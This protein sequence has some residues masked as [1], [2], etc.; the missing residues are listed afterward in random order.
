V[1]TQIKE[2]SVDFGVIYCTAAYSA[3]LDI[4]DYATAEMCGQ[5]VYPAAVLKTAANPEAAAA[6]LDFLTTG[7]AMAVFEAAGFSKP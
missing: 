4:L 5:A 1:T 6:F 3:E 7:G 2:A